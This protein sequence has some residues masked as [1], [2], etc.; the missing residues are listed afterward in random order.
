[1]LGHTYIDRGTEKTVVLLHGI[2]SDRTQL[3]R[4]WDLPYNI[5]AVD[6]FNE[7][8]RLERVRPDI[9]ELLALHHV[10]RFVLVGYSLGGYVAQYLLVKGMRPEAVVLI[11]AGVRLPHGRLMHNIESLNTA[12]PD[13]TQRALARIITWYRSVRGE[14]PERPPTPEDIQSTLSFLSALDEHDFGKELEGLSVL[15]LVLQGSGDWV[16]PASLARPLAKTLQKAR[17]VEWK[18]DHSTVI[19]DPRSTRL[20]REFLSSAP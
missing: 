7:G 2:A 8:T 6:L 12:S 15:T 18:T 1:M 14:P 17:Y 3:R 10:E 9:E 5:L 4:F 13:R 19:D 16:V 20:L 11:A